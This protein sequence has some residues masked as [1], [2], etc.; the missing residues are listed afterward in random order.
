MNFYS[1]HTGDGSLG[2]GLYVSKLTDAH[3]LAKDLA[4]SFTPAQVMD[5]ALVRIDLV[6]IKSDRATLLKMLNGGDDWQSAP[7]R[8]WAIKERGGLYEMA[9]GE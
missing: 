9:A 1:V 7:I 4:A 5:R 2:K 6:E 8:T 3:K